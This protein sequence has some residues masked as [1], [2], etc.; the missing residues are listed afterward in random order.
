[1]ADGNLFPFSGRV[2]IYRNGVW[3]TVCD[4]HWNDTNSQVVC[5]QLGY[6]SEHATL[7]RRVPAGKGPILLENVDCNHNQTNL[8]ACSHNGFENHNNCGHVE[9]VGVLCLSSRKCCCNG[10]C[11]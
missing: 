3:G 11:K 7:D 1:M 6:G 8:L 4:K 2:E 5:K 9:D 10:Y